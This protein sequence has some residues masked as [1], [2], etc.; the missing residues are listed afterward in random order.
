MWTADHDVETGNTST[1]T[2]IF[3]GRGVLSESQGPVWMIGGGSEHNV[4]HQYNF[5]GARDHFLG[6]LQVCFLNNFRL[7]RS[8]SLQTE[9]PYYQ[10]T[11]NPPAPFSINSAYKDPTFFPSPG[12]SWA[13]FI[14]NSTNLSV[15]SFRITLRPGTDS[16]LLDPSPLQTS[17]L[18]ASFTELAPTPSLSTMSRI[19][20][21]GPPPARVASITSTTPPLGSTSLASRRSASPICSVSTTSQSFPR[22]QTALARRPRFFG[23]RSR[24]LSSSHDSCLSSLDVINRSRYL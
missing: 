11:P 5:A 12:D 24:R 19:P 15:P 1:Q 6:V 23:T 14:Q 7:L 8:R 4:L 22:A 18:I 20:A 21:L 13:L 17:L 16:P 2:T 10:P 3:S 9:S